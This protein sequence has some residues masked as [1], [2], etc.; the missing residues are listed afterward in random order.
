MDSPDATHSATPT[1][2][3][4]LPLPLAGAYDYAPPAGVTLA[5]GD[6][7][8]APLGKREV[9][10]VVWGQGSG[11]VAA[12]RLKR[13]YGKLDLPPMPES[14]SNFINWVADYTI[15]PPGA[16]LRL[17]MRGPQAA[18]SVQPVSLYQLAGPPPAR[19]SAARATLL[20]C[21]ADGQPRSAAEFA[22][23]ANVATSVVRGL[24]ASATLIA[25]QG[26]RAAAVGAPNPNH[27]GPAL[28]SAQSDAASNLRDAVRAKSY[29]CTLLEGVTGAGKTEVYF[30]AVAEA[31]RQG[32]QALILLPEIA[33]TVQFLARFEARFGAPP[34][35]WHSEL[36][37][38]KRRDAWRAVAS[39]AARVVVGARSALF[40]PFTQLGLI[41]VDEEHDAAFK[42][43]DGVA[44][45]AR[46]MA[47]VRAHQLSIPIILSSATPSLE[48]VVNAQGGRY[49]ALKLPDR[50]G[51]AVLPQ[52]EAVDMRTAN[53]P[54][55][56]YI[57]PRLQELMAETLACGE[58]VLLF[59]NRRGYAP[60]TLCRAC[61][62]RMECPNCSA[63]LVEHR[64]R[65][66]LLCH[67]C[68]YGA[69]KPH[70]CPACEV[71]N[72][73]AS[74][75]PGVERLA[76]E[77]ASAFPEITP[78]VISGDDDVARVRETIEAFTRGESKILIGTQIV[79]KGHHFP[80]LTLVGVI[81]ADLGLA[82]GDLRAAERTFQL[83]HQV[84]GRAG[85]AERPGHA[86]L[87]T[88]MPE[89]PVMQALISGGR[90]QFLAAESAARRGRGLPPFG[91]LVALIVS[92]PDQK[93]VIGAATAL[94]R[95]APHGP[96]LQV[97][98]P[99]PAPLALLRGRY[100][101][102]LL[103]M[104]TRQHDVQALLRA[105]LSPIR[106]PANVRLMVD[107]DPYSFM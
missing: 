19:L 64:F 39:G 97:L 6:F 78:A 96:Q 49:K 26:D 9:M 62:H 47:V 84:S 24:I 31:L 59:L 33:L 68:G 50:F 12:A 8:R 18:M 95:S 104:A 21:A 41:I 14:L 45:H 11:A 46:D 5:P 101:Y 37:T 99:A 35:A 42:Q 105:W 91:R 13:L 61:G 70:A 53:L 90:E 20:S 92:G 102:R 69:A 88:Y 52:I 44:Y 80:G 51:G 77:A 40:L 56:K 15:N 2:S 85:R 10:G 87:Q 4:L 38:P 81:D 103:L 79:A 89:H 43:E 74:C 36:S 1:V 73:L 72:K 94:A 17:A 32:Q 76:E 29:C 30:E 106:L 67:H 71:E 7:V 60:L 65:N 66:Q 27:P 23:L 86:L 25:V 54:A 82:G 75:G 58:Q 98:G 100:R 3:V 48:T 83:L 93:R 63:W 57:S 16:V 107:V 28:S 34:I 55:D 22:R